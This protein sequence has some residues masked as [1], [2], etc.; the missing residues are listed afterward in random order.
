MKEKFIPGVYN[1]CDRWCERCSFTSR[2]RNYESTGRLPTEQKDINNEAFWKNLTSNFKLTIELIQKAAKERGIDLTKPLTAEEEREFKSRKG[3]LD[4]QV[5]QHPLIQL[6]K[7]YQ[8]LVR[9]F[10]EHTD[11]LVNKTRELVDHLHLGIKS[12]E[13]VTYTVAEIGD[14][15]D[16]IQWY[17]FFIDAK[18]QRA[19]RG[20]I[21]GE[22]WETENGFQKDSDGS[23]KIA[24]IGIE[25]SIDAWAKLYD[26]LPS[27][28][29]NALNALSLLTQLKEVTL[30]E[31]PQAMVFKRA[32]FDD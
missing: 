32:G 27:S 22:D 28:E 6:C 12:E 5:N 4:S 9:P 10:I 31:F 7:Q 2:C 15:F 20:K 11:G 25:R 26:Q 29:D 24:L 1:Y 8:S 13:D 30:K 19:L 14:C 21:E 3:F 17:I 23:A 16:I 18:L